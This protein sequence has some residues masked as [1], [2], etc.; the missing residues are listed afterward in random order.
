MSDERVFEEAPSDP[1]HASLGFGG[2]A[3]ASVDVKTRAIGRKRN[4]YGKALGDVLLQNGQTVTS[5]VRDNLTTAF[6]GAGYQVAASESGAGPAAL[7]ADVRIKDFWAWFQPGFW[8]LTL[9]TNITTDVQFAGAAAPMTITVHAEDKRQMATESAW[10]EI[11][12]R[13]LTDY[14]AK[15]TA[16]A[17]SLH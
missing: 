7:V 2:A 14:R 12:D 16:A 8:E 17:A 5:V 15:A 10:T 6:Q 13:A 3:A 1:S 4:G 9:S 11:I